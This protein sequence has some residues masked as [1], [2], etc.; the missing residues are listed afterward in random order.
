[1]THSPSPSTDDRIRALTEELR[2]AEAVDLANAS[3]TRLILNQERLRGALADSLRL[4][5]DL[6]RRIEELEEGR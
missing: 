6:L 5:G 3:K 4:I 1:V 2:I